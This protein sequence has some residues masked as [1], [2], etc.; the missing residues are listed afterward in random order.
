MVIVLGVIA[1]LLFLSVITLQRFMRDMAIV[2]S[3]L[4]NELKEMKGYLKKMS[5]K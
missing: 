5:E 1:F 3:D 2:E 4:L